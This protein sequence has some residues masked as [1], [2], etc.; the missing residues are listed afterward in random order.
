LLAGIDFFEQVVA[1]Q[2]AYS[3]IHFKNRIQTNG[4]LMTEAFARLFAQHHF[5]VGFSLDGPEALHNHHRKYATDGN[6]RGPFTD[7]M[8][9][10]E[11]Y[12]QIAGVDNVAVICVVT[13]KS[14]DYA[15]ELFHFFK[16]LRAR[17]QL[18]IFDVRARDLIPERIDSTLPFEM[19]PRNSELARF[20]ISLF[21][22]WFYDD[23]DH[24][25]FKELR[26]EVKMLLQP[27]VVRGVPYDKRRCDIRRTI[28]DPE[29]YVYSCDQYINDHDTALG[30]ISTDEL[31]HMVDKKLRLWE[32]IKRHVRHRSDSMGC[33][34][35]RWGRQCSGGCITCM[36]YHSRLARARK[37]GRTMADWIHMP[38]SP[39]LADV[40]G[41]FY[42]CD[43]LRALRDH[44]SACIAHQLPENGFSAE[45]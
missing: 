8:A 15:N 28:I 7:V 31:T 21:D 36:R 33:H 16:D 25:D 22:L 4:T 44:A 42:Y 9:G 13:Q 2:S 34:T 17:V 18:D 12:R 39:E 5:D 45:R 30:H 1:M 24:V 35:C 19:A 37:A 40:T 3:G 26:D 27:D 32:D 43:A 10:I 29:G 11:R 6:C 38:E 20:L 23:S 41:E 14:M